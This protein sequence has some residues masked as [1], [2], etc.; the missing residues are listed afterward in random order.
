[1]AKE[2]HDE[3][4]ETPAAEKKESKATEEA[5]KKAGKERFNNG[6]RRNR[7]VKDPH[8]LGEFIDKVKGK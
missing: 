7:K 1:M 6:K 4:K 2:C 5:E 3:K 8:G